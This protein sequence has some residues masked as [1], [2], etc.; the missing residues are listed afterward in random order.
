M[1]GDQKNA[2]PKLEAGMIRLGGIP[3][4]FRISLTSDRKGWT[5]RHLLS[6]LFSQF[7]LLCVA[8]LFEAFPLIDELAFNLGNGFAVP[9]L[10][11]G[12]ELLMKKD[13]PLGDLG[14]ITAVDPGK[15]LFVFLAEN[16]PIFRVVLLKAFHGELVGT[17]HR[18][19]GR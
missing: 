13:L 10:A 7:I 15:A 14:G 8:F 4:A 1:P 3:V 16:G 18:K 19:E 6:G 11:C 17:F 5:V 2:C 9:I 12:G